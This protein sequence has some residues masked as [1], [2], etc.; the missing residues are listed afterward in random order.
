MVD[1]KDYV[2][3]TE[4]APPLPPKGGYRGASRAALLGHQQPGQATE[5]IETVKLERPRRKPHWVG[6][7]ALGGAILFALVL[8]MIVLVGTSGAIFNVTM[9]ML[10][11]LVLAGVVAALVIPQARRLGIAALTVALVANVA[12]LGSVSALQVAQSGS[13]IAE[14]TPSEQRSLGYPS[15]EGYTETEI[16][17]QPSLEEERAKV[18]QMFKE[19]RE[20]LSREYGVT[21]TRTGD[22]DLRLMRNGRGGES[23]LYSAVFESWTTNEPVHDLALKE[24][25]LDTAMDVLRSHGYLDPYYLHL[26]D[27]RLPDVQMQNLYGG[28]TPEEQ[29]LWSWLTWENWYTPTRVYLEITDLSR[30]TTGDFRDSAEARRLQPGDPI[31][32]FWLHASSSPLLSEDDVEEFTERMSEY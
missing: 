13:Y 12:T 5:R 24:A 32:G 3:R 19:V 9:L 8:G 16:L 27:G 23:M 14:K 10:Q 4:G 2:T 6:W 26:D 11:L 7:V 31:E 29:V 28:L 20:E 18:T 15:V 1:G 17:D 21:W 25:M 22:E 30:D